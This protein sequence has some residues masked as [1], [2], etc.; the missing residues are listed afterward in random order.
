MTIWR[1]VAA[2]VLMFV[3]CAM[4]QQPFAPPPSPRVTY[5]FNPDWRFFREDVAGAEAMG[6]D[7]SAWQTVST[8]HT[9]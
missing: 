4:A 1:S 9:L 6:F 5:N 3:P 8:P 7:D 2:M